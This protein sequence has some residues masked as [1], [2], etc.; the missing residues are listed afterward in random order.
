MRLFCNC[1]SFQ[2]KIFFFFNSPTQLKSE[3]TEKNDLGGNVELVLI[4]STIKSEL[5]NQNAQ[6][7]KPRAVAYLSWVFFSL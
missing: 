2:E 6:S 3:V 7:G 4:Q 5:P 1:S